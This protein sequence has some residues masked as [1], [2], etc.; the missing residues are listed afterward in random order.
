[1]VGRQAYF[2]VD[3]SAEKLEGRKIS[4]HFAQVVWETVVNDLTYLTTLACV[5][6]QQDT[7]EN[8]SFRFVVGKQIPEDKGEISSCKDLAMWLALML[9]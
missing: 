7:P 4:L 1:M 6:A 8:K 9:R 3:A 5:S 2:R